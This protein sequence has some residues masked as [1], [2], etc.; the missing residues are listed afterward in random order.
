MPIFD[1]EKAFAYFRSMDS[2][3]QE[4]AANAFI[5]ARNY[6]REHRKG[7]MDLVKPGVN[8]DKT[9]D[10][11]F[12]TANENE[13]LKADKI[14]LEKSVKDLEARNT[15]LER[16]LAGEKKSSMSWTV[17]Y[18]GSSVGKFVK[19]SIFGFLLGSASVTGA[20]YILE[21]KHVPIVTDRWQWLKGKIMPDE[22]SLP[23]SE[24][25]EYA[26]VETKLANYR[27]MPSPG[28]ENIAGQLSH[29]SCL[30]LVPEDGLKSEWQKIA[31]TAD[32]QEYQGYISR[33]VITAMPASGSMN[34]QA[35]I[36]P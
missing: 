10:I 5:N 3:S 33:N 30:K 16:E 27:N 11:D 26:T 20:I 9:H 34:C 13:K 6:L 29:G 22:A 17:K 32:G 35:K 25:S 14:K 19:S 12:K 31:F 1:I 21:T 8:P 24:G 2:S 28:K 36:E 18:Y 7:F 23:I 4:T 15:V